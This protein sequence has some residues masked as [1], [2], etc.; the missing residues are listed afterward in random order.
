MLR[1]FTAK[2]GV[3]ARVAG[4]SLLPGGGGGAKR[5][6]G[7]ALKLLL[8]LSRA[9]SAFSFASCS[10]M[11]CKSSASRWLMWPKSSSSHHPWDVAP[12]FCKRYLFADSHTT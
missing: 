2:L 11:A 8:R 6:G 12:D 4:R 7:A 3:R 10:A 1:V 9:L 5:G